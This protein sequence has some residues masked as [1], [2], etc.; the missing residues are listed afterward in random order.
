VLLID[1]AN[2][3]AAA[4]AIGFDIDCRKPLEALR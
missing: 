1:G 3:L 2:L 4:K